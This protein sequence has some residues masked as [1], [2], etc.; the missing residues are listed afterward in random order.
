MARG[1]DGLSDIG[2]TERPR[3]LV[4]AYACDPSRGSE[5]GAG[6]GLLQALARFADC[7]VLVGPEGWGP[8]GEWERANPGSPI[9]FVLVADPRWARPIT[10]T[11]NRIG[12]F[13]AYLGW[14]P[15]AR[16]AARRLLASEWF[17]AAYH[18]TYSTYWLPA[19]AT[20][21]GL[22]S[23]WGPVGGGVVTP[24]VPA[25]PGH[26]EAGEHGRRPERGNEKAAAGRRRRGG[27]A[28][29]PRRLQSTR[30]WAHGTARRHR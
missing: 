13:L 19:P 15:R 23:V 20:A 2:P 3:L 14:L 29:Q 26:L 18:A 6:W 24:L 9:R 27:G 11:H 22:P 17:D 10:K 12:F 7:V 16:A 21:L 5:E 4:F 1:S 8:I 30:R 28:P 25:D